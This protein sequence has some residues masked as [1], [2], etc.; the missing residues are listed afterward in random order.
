VGS[1]LQTESHVP[2]PEQDFSDPRS[3]QKADLSALKEQIVNIDKEQKRELYEML[4]K[5]IGSFTP[6]L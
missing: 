1:E 5:Y 2:T 6:K 4:E 3:L